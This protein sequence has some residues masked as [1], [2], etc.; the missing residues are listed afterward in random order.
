MRRI[1]FALAL[2]L[3]LAAAIGGGYLR[4]IALSYV[5]WGDE[6]SQ[7]VVV[8]WTVIDGPGSA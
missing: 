3:G 1:I 2:S 7:E 5:E 8:P 4:R 6:S